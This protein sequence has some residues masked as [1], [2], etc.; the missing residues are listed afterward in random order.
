MSKFRIGEEVIVATYAKNGQEYLITKI[1]TRGVVVENEPDSSGDIYIAIES[2]EYVDVKEDDLIL[3][4]I[5]G[6]PLWAAL[7]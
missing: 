7:K 5:V 4:P 1:G 2:D 6:S 3:D